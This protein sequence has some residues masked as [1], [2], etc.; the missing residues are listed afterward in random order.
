MTLG[1]RERKKARTRAAIQ[2][3]A[4]ALFRTQGYAQTSVEQIAAAA[5]V[6]PSTFFRYFPTKEDS[7]LTEF[8]D[9]QMVEVVVNA[10]A[11][12]SPLDAVRFAVVEFYGTMNEEQLQLELIRN[13]LIESVPEL[14][15]G[16]GA[17]IHRPME[18]LTQALARRLHRP[19]DDP[20]LRVFAGALVGGM[21]A[22]IPHPDE[23]PD[24]LRDVFTGQIN[25]VLDILDTMLTLP[26]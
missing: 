26:S 9:E 22:G 8:I 10:P 14:Q 3:H 5:E 18:L 23:L 13:Q 11:G 2:Q 6:S 20:E 19:I 24:D 25:R 12:L 4:L 16:A 1:L 15:R 7:V 21:L 17:E